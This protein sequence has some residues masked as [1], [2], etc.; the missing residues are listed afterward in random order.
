MTMKS[1]LVN[2]LPDES[3]YM[4]D[5]VPITGHEIERFT[6]L[7]NLHLTD[8]S[9]IVGVNTASVYTKKKFST[10]L[11]PSVCIM[12]RLYSAF[13]ELLPI[14]K[15]PDSEELIAKIRSIDPTFMRSHFGPLLGLATN[16]SF[17]LHKGTERSSQVVRRLMFLIDQLITANPKNWE[18]I[19]NAVEIE[20]TASSII[21]S[22][23]VWSDGGWAKSRR[24]SKPNEGVTSRRPKIRKESTTAKP[25]IRKTAKPK[26]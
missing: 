17:R 11:A 20:A 22:S 12:L 14:T 6:T 21:P 15:A 9:F 3:K 25:L 24:A 4:G 13:P 23:K 19:K 5:P 16:S 8:F 7:H 2:K 1:A 26:D 10:P 18:I